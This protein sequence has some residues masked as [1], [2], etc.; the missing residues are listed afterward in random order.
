MTIFD[1][2]LCDVDCRER[3]LEEMWAKARSASQLRS[4][5]TWGPKSQLHSPNARMAQHD[6]MA[7]G[8]QVL[9]GL[10]SQEYN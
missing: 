2:R 7:L 4:M 9:G 8:S 10:Y 5:R 3:R 1:R 6:E